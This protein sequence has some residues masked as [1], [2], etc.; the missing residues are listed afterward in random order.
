MSIKT[1]SHRPLFIYEQVF[2]LGVILRKLTD[3]LDRPLDALFFL[4]FFLN[5]CD[6]YQFNGL[7]SCYL[8]GEEVKKQ[9]DQ[10][11]KFG[12]E[13]FAIKCAA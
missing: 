9:Q 11:T 3:L 6:Y 13:C 2:R 4:F 7:Y 1:S 10:L 5:F 12:F 8:V